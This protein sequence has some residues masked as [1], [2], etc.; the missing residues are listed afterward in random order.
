MIQT[1]PDN[2][3]VLCLDIDQSS[4][5]AFVWYNTIQKMHSYCMDQS[6]CFVVQ[7]ITAQSYEHAEDTEDRITQY[8]SSALEGGPNGERPEIRIYSNFEV[9]NNSYKLSMVDDEFDFFLD[10]MEMDP[11]VVNN[12]A[13]LSAIHICFDSYTDQSSTI[14]GAMDWLGGYLG[15]VPEENMFL[16]DHVTGLIGLERRFI[17]RGADIVDRRAIIYGVLMRYTQPVDEFLPNAIQP[18]WPSPRFFTSTTLGLCA[19]PCEEMRTVF[20]GREELALCLAR[21]IESVA[22]EQTSALREKNYLSFNLRFPPTMSIKSLVIRFVTKLKIN[23]EDDDEHYE[24]TF[25]L[26]CIYVDRYLKKNPMEYLSLLN[27]HE[28]LLSA[29]LLAHKMNDDDYLHDTFM[30]WLGKVSLG[31]LKKQERDFLKKIEWHLA[32]SKEEFDLYYQLLSAYKVHGFDEDAME[33]APEEQLPH[34]AQN[35]VRVVAFR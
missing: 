25:V 11:I 24:S 28:L 34:V 9:Q 21:L 29:L 14:A 20:S 5:D 10:D 35:T 18:A 26:M 12:P 15:G 33:E 1:N 4:V 23:D 31:E 6:I 19:R 16:L 3:L 22:I 7:V 32:V 30:A 8:L 13:L 2:T 27:S 17:A